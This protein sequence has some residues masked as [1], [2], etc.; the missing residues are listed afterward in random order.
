MKPVIAM[1]AQP[2]G[3]DSYGSRS[4]QQGDG[5]QRRIL[6]KECEPVD[7]GSLVAHE[8][9]VGAAPFRPF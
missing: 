5:Q 2:N 1:S 9:Q 7:E 8:G 6:K 3:G 4:F